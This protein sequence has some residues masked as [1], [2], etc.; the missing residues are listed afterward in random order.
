MNGMGNSAWV[1]V[2]A[3]LCLLT[4]S[5]CAARQMHEYGRFVIDKDVTARFE[6][7]RVDPGLVYYISGSDNLPNAIVGISRAYTLQSELWKRRDLDEDTLK[8]LVG[9]MAHRVLATGSGLHGFRVEA[10]GGDTV[11]VWFSVMKGTTFVKVAD[12]N[13]FLGTPPIDIY[14]RNE[15]ERELPL[16][17]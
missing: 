17:P 12:G 10:P 4:L 3:V 1:R 16:K 5:G 13:V 6:A 14:E 9:A 8:D 15:T 11:G 2:A 7:Y